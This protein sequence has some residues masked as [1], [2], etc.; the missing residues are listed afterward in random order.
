MKKL[1]VLL[2]TLAAIFF[3][4]FS[5]TAYAQED[6]LT[7]DELVSE[8]YEESGAGELMYSL[9]DTAREF[10]SELNI[11]DFSAESTSSVEMPEFIS[12]VGGA[13]REQIYSPLRILMSV[14]GIIL[15]TAVFDVLKTSTLSVSVE[16]VLCAVSSLC[17]VTVIAPPMLEL[18]EE[19]S[20]TITSS[21]DFMLIYVPVITVLTVTSGHEISGGMFYSVMIYMCSAITQI[22]SKIIVP[23]LKSVLSLSVVASVSSS[24]S[25]DGFITLFRRAVKWILCFCMSLFVAFITMKAIVSAAEDSVSNKVAKFAIN[26]FVPLVGGALS[27]AYQTVVSCVSVLKSGVGVVA[28]IAIFAIFLPAV[29]KCAV[30]QAA[31][32]ICGAVCELF[33]VKKISVLMSS[34]G[35][36]LSS[37]S[38]ILLSIMVIYIVSTAI[39]IIVGG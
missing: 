34:L 20:R 28:M 33:G 10:L 6:T 5:V 11:T 18:V 12:A 2:P 22:T 16:M 25:L 17:V 30:W 29:L 32:A 37:I 36:V 19:L 24:V 1:C 7:E 21:G 31:V 8:I 35:S 14:F 15:I 39:V 3:A 23:L 38:A 13:L 4:L 27:D 9:P 26:N